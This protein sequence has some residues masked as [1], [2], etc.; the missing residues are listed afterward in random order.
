[1]KGLVFRIQRFCLHD[2]PGIRTTVFLKGC[3][4]HCVWCHNPEGQDS[5]IQL[6]YDAARCTSCGACAAA[7]PSNSRTPQHFAPNRSL[8]TA[9]GKCVSVCPMQANSIAG[10]YMQA[11]DVL[12]SVLRDRNFF[13]AS[14]GGMTLSGGEPS[15]QSSFSL[16]LLRLGRRAE[17]DLCIETAGCGSSA[18]YE[19]AAALGCRF[20][21]DLKC[22]DPQ[23]HLSLVGMHLK[24]ILENL[25]HLMTQKAPIV[26]RLPLIPSCNDS[27]LD[28]AAMRTFLS[29][30]R[31][32]FETVQ[33]LPYHPLGE[34]KA[35]KLQRLPIC[36]ITAPTRAQ[37][38]AFAAAINPG[39]ISVEIL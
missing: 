37:I 29:T 2:G 4:L 26:L 30:Q 5:H 21:F 9:C 12:T 15:V 3:P 25:E 1:M 18:F 17:L 7:C 8:C 14:G 27:A 19:Q 38:E 13:K 31:G 20:L 39:G 10:M 33:I 16:E 23:R 24:P 35:K 28:T 34:S 32:R 36:G 11:E 22:M 6:L